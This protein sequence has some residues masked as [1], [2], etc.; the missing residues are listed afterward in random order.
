MIA[1]SLSNHLAEA[2]S[3]VFRRVMGIDVQIA[4]CRDPEIEQAVP[5]KQG[6]E[7]VENANA[8]FNV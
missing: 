8:G 6:E 5:G 7:V 2:D 1:E 3:H 4:P